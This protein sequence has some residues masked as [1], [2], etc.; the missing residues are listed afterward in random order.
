MTNKKEIDR[1]A[2]LAGSDPADP[3]SAKPLTPD[4][5]SGA[6]F[7]FVGSGDASDDALAPYLV[8]WVYSVPVHCREQFVEAVHDFEDDLGDPPSITDGLGY[9]GTYSVSVSSAAPEFEFR[10]L[11]SLSALKNLQEAQR[12]DRRSN[13]H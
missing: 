7:P 11:W 12:C 2:D 3:P 10:T 6:T 1:I 8:I 5:R 4:V 13:E 9:R